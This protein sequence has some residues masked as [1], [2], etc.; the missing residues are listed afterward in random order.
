VNIE[1]IKRQAR[2]DALEEAAKLC[3][4]FER[5][6]RDWK[7][8]ACETADE[9]AARI[10]KLAAEPLSLK[11]ANT[12]CSQCG[13]EFGPG[14]S[15]YSHCIDHQAQGEA[16]NHTKRYCAGGIILGWLLGF[17]CGWVCNAQEVEHGLDIRDDVASVAGDYMAGISEE[18][19]KPATPI[20]RDFHA[21]LQSSLTRR[22]IVA[23]YSV[24]I[25]DVI[26]TRQVQLNPCHCM[27]EDELGPIVKSSIGMTAY[28][29]GVATAV[30]YGAYKLWQHGHPKL[31]RAL[32]IGEI[33]GDGEAGVHNEW[34]NG[35][36]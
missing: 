21:Y 5:D 33:I 18:T 36:H 25:L 7:E 17:C 19:S 24:R 9:I 1:E 15:G 32:Q 14:N 6:G 2:K 3:D 35:Q 34:L 20:K 12:Y 23:D 4:N 31:A 8:Y 26:S 29:L 10:R 16:M 30:E 27:H 13:R 11:F 28:S 22:L